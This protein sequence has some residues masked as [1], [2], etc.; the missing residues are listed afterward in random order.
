MSDKGQA[1]LAEGSALLFP[2][3][4]VRAHSLGNRIRIRTMHCYV[5]AREEFPPLLQGFPMVHSI[6]YM[7]AAA[8]HSAQ[9]YRLL[10]TIDDVPLGSLHP[11]FKKR[12]FSRISSL[13][14]V[15]TSKRI[16][17]LTLDATLQRPPEIAAQKVRS[18]TPFSKINSAPTRPP[19]ACGD[20]P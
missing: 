5:L 19:S 1:P 2:A 3:H 20:N 11:Q 7:W 15:V 8:Q 12:C 13:P 4:H 17:S 18:G 16:T 10:R 9:E 14:P 6:T